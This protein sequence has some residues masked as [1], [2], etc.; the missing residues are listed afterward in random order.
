MKK[1]FF[2][3]IFLL[4]CEFR[5]A[6][7]MES[8]QESPPAEL[9]ENLNRTEQLKYL[10]NLLKESAQLLR[11]ASQQR[12]AEGDEKEET[13]Q[14]MSEQE[15]ESNLIRCCVRSC[16]HKEKTMY[17]MREHVKVLHNYCTYWCLQHCK[18]QFLSK[19]DL[20]AHYNQLPQ[21]KKNFRCDECNHEVSITF[22]QY[23][24]HKQDHK[25]KYSRGKQKRVKH[26]YRC[27]SRSCGTSFPRESHCFAH[28]FLVH[29]LR[30]CKQLVSLSEQ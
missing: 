1:C 15:S 22:E 8:G 10:E 6:S 9:L 24:Q 4:L 27:K 28:E 13:E 17:Y 5:A 14:E 12:P 18:E 21:Q 16:N 26:L 23:K 19:I 25:K 3:M 30:H 20:E 29:G 7:A 2:A 11:E